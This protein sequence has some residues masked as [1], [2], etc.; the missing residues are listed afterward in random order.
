VVGKG[1]VLGAH[2]V[3]RGEIPDFS[4]AGG[5]PAKVLKRRKKPTRISMR[6][7]SV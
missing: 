4:V 2:A 5:V 3:V 1:C 6:A 7:K